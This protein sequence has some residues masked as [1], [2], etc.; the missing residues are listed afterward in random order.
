M[1]VLLE[2][3]HTSIRVCGVDYEKDALAVGSFG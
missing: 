1:F 2:A 3:I